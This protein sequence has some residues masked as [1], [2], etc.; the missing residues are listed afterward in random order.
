MN[1]GQF[2]KQ[3][4]D[5]QRTSDE[6]VSYSGENQVANSALRKALDRVKARGHSDI[7]APHTTHHSHSRK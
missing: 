7:A 1:E 3:T 4:A 5:E 6:V 2:R